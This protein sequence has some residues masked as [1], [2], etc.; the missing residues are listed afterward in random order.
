MGDEMHIPFFEVPTR[1]ESKVWYF[2]A[3]NGEKTM[4][5]EKID[6]CRFVQKY[7]I[8][9]SHQVGRIEDNNRKLVYH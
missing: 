2:E 9:Q 3:S 4:S 7:G 6:V 1:Q 5:I 8:G